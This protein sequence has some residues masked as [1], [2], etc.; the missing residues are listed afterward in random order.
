VRH[1]ATVCQQGEWPDILSSIHNRG[2]VINYAKGRGVNQWETDLHS[3]AHLDLWSPLSTEDGQ[4]KRTIKTRSI[5]TGNLSDPSL[6]QDTGDGGG[7]WQLVGADFFLFIVSFWVQNL[8]L[9]CQHTLLGSYPVSLP[10]PTLT[11]VTFI[12]LFEKG[13]LNA[14][15][16]SPQSVIT[17][18][19]V[20]CFCPDF[21]YLF[22]KAFPTKALAN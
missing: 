6:V 13:Y 17:A 21:L 11:Q 20:L 1:E 5:P 12:W 16:I 4:Q 19:T 15:P 14:S 22:L 3:W 2:G 8:L 18:K 10:F 9:R 7:D